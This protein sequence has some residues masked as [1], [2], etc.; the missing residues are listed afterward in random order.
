MRIKKVSIENF[1]CLHQL[2]LDI[3]D[4]TVLIGANSTGKS[5]VLK[6]LE[7][8]FEGGELSKED[9]C[10]LRTEAKVSVSVT[11]GD[12]TSADREALHSYATG[13]TA[14][15]WRT[16]SVG[17]KDKLTGRAMAYPP[18]EEIRQHEKATDLRKAYTQLRKDE[19][20]LN[21]PSV[22]SRDTALEAMAAW[23]AEHT[24][25]LV[26]AT[27][28]ATHL[29]GFAGQLKLAGRFDYVFVPAVSDA[30]EQTR[31]ARG[32]LVQQIVSRSITD[33]NGIEE[34]LKAIHKETTKKM[35]AVMHEEHGD[36]L[37]ELS[38]RF[39]EALQEYVPTG[40]VNFRP[41]PPELKMPSLQVDLKVSDAGLETDV[42]RQGHGFQRALLMAAVQELARVG[43]S[44]GDTPALFL[45]IEEPEL[46]QHPAQARHFART[47]A[48]LPRAGEGAIQVAYATHS[49]YFVDPSRYERLR[50][51]RKEVGAAS[52]PTA[53]VSSATIEGVAN[54][55]SGVV[56]DAQVPRRVA[57]TLQRT[58][59]E[60]VFAHA[61]LLVEGRTDEALLRGVADREGGFDAMGVA[62]VQVNGKW[63]LPTPWAIL[64]ELGV[65]CFMAFDGDR[66][67]EARGVTAGKDP[68]KIASEKENT[69]RGNRTLL[70]LLSVQEE[71][72]PSTGVYR[73]HAVFAD[74]L[75]DEL[76]N[77]W[78]EMVAY[79]EGLKN[80]PGE[81][82]PKP[83]DVY[84]QAAR[85]VEGEIPALIS[86]IVD[87]VKRL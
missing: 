71:D 45:A 24:D 1:R 35:S 76:T 59:S 17:D 15:F 42:G 81:W 51:F 66:S 3:D 23:E 49:E 6:A 80:E 61:V 77:S 39:T 46:Y 53:K 47:L 55:L 31:H 63:N 68:R 75:E 36:A 41:Q 5:S 4:L 82:R 19:P 74:C 44:G 50:R 33:L 40:K 84:Q 87:A 73:N 43:D 26:P 64:N 12:L 9:V 85:D 72:W 60:A 38:D 27:S 83:E 7:W 14:V 56:Q 52:C 22:T 29:F 48:E 10:G 57:I 34:R 69:T 79:A 32:T 20:S 78:P 54:R 13:E 37:T 58:L 16:W 18:F 8:F 28:S 62:V 30:E 11:F 25:D 2:E 70:S 21:L 86:S 65:P 67:V